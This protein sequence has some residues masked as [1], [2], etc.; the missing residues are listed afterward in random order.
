MKLYFNICPS[1]CKHFLHFIEEHIMFIFTNTAKIYQ[2]SSD[3]PK[4]HLWLLSVTDLTLLFSCISSGDRNNF[5]IFK[6]IHF[7]VF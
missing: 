6:A 7:F 5:C 4:K 2:H 3:M 1:M